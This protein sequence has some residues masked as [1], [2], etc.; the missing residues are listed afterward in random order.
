MT[1]KNY[2]LE[3]YKLI[4][5]DIS[6]F[7]WHSETEFFVFPYLFELNGFIKS[8]SEL[9]GKGIFDDEGFTAHIGDGYA[10]INL[11]DVVSDYGVSLE[12]IF[13]YDEYK[14]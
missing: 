9:F 7:G 13:P 4:T 11:V 14:H 5:N 12:T 3:L 8:L 1:E 10:C 6:E 2:G